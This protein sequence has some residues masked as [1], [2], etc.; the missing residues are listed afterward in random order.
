MRIS[1]APMAVFLLLLLVSQAA[2]DIH[3]PYRQKI[4]VKTRPERKA[5]LAG[6]TYNNLT[7]EEQPP[8]RDNVDHHNAAGIPHYRRLGCYRLPDADDK[9]RAAVLIAYMLFVSSLI[10]IFVTCC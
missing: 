8:S 2:A 4:E 5:N 3:I 10:I 1:T 6:K 9:R 7:P